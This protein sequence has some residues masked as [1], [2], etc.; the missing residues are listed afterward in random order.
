MD[1]FLAAICVLAVV[2]IAALVWAVTDRPG[3]V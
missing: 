1:L 3:R 2:G